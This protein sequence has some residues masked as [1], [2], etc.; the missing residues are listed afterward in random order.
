MN[1]SP[2]LSVCAVCPRHCRLRDGQTGACRARKAEGGRVVAANYGK[3]TSL[4]LDGTTATVGYTTDVN[5]VMSATAAKSAFYVTSGTTLSFQ[6]VVKTKA[7]L[8]DEWTVADTRTVTVELGT[9]KSGEITVDVGALPEVAG[10]MT[11][12]LKK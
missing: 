5:T 2:S 12:E 3:I 4:A 1:D 7:N 8:A 6:L 9:E 11:I 10:F